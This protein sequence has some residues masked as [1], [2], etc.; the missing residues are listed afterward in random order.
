V[1]DAMQRFVRAC[2]AE[3]S[4]AEAAHLLWEHDRECAPVVD[5]KGRLAAI[6]TARDIYKAAHTN[7]H[8]DVK[9]A[10]VMVCD[11]ATARPDESLTSVQMTMR[12]RGVRRLPVVDGDGRLIG[13]ISCEDLCRWIDDG[14]AILSL[15]DAASQLVA[16]IAAIERAR[17]RAS[18]PGPLPPLLA[19]SASPSRPAPA[20]A[21]TDTNGTAAKMP[22][23]ATS[24][25]R[26]LPRG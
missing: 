9:V 10:Q 6:I 20:G 24:S 3:D 7:G 14:G 23:A 4:L 2:H 5:A 12:T 19:P 15:H 1:K 26:A 18:D 11:I 13:L 8:G 21:P 25:T 16:T 17:N 22:A